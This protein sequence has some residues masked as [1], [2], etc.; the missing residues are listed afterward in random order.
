MKPY[1][2]SLSGNKEGV[3]AALAQE[4]R[5]ATRSHDGGALQ[6]GAGTPLL[7]AALKGH[8]DICVYT[9]VAL[10]FVFFNDASIKSDI[11]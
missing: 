4:G 9:L 5:D 3:I 8:T 7:A 1:N 11:R 2:S 6:S 10:Q